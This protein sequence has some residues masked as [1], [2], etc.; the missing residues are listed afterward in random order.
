MTACFLIF[1]YVSFELSYDSFHSKADR[2]YRIV[3]DIKTPQ[4]LFNADRPAW[5]VPPNVKDEFPEVESF[6]RIAATMKCW[7]EKEI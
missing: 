2:I 7:S 1:L 4:K 6:V 3:A 5:A